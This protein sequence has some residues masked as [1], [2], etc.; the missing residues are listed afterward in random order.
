MP[1]V[2][3]RH[4]GQAQTTRRHPRP[5]TQRL[6]PANPQSHR[7]V[8]FVLPYAVALLIALHSP[9]SRFTA[10]VLKLTKLKSTTRC[11][12]EST[13]GWTSFESVEQRQKKTAS[14]P[15]LR[16]VFPTS[17]VRRS[18]PLLLHHPRPLLPGPP[19]AG[20]Q[21]RPLAKPLIQSIQSSH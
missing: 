17:R 15:H 20:H 18:P 4:R 12:Y 5:R 16:Q 6:W 9:C 14:S 13:V 3:V 7:I 2:G 1:A 21:H 19:S 10:A 11:R 8:F